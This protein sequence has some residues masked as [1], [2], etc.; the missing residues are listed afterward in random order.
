MKLWRVGG[1]PKPT[2]PSAEEGG[3]SAVSDPFNWDCFNYNNRQPDLLLFPFLPFSPSVV[4]TGA[5]VL[6]MFARLPLTLCNLLAA[7]QPPPLH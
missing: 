5:G 2:P 4:L 6:Q 3:S 1:G 7:N